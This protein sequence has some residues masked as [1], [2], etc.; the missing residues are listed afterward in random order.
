MHAGGGADNGGEKRN[1]LLVSQLLPIAIDLALRSN[2][3]RRVDVL[4]VCQFA[5][6][7]GVAATPITFLRDAEVEDQASVASL[8]SEV[9]PKL[10]VA[11]PLARAYRDSSHGKCGPTAR[12]RAPTKPSTRKPARLTTIIIAL[13]YLGDAVD[14]AD[15]AV[16]LVVGHVEGRGPGEGRGDDRWILFVNGRWPITLS[17]QNKRGALAISPAIVVLYS[18]L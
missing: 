18:L 11:A 12:V 1:V 2:M 9:V 10:H 6:L 7:Q 3:K 13:L 14:V 5:I 17:A 4:R 16:I 8:V 15:I